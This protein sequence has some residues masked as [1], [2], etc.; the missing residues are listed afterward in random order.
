PEGGGGDGL[1]LVMELLRGETLE[2]HLKRR[3]P[4]PAREA[5][6]I[7]VLLLSALAHAHATGIVHRDVTPANVFLAIDP[8]GH[9]TP[10]LLDFGIAKVPAGDQQTLDGRALGTPRYMAPERIRDEGVLDG[11]SDLF[12]LGVVLYEM[13]TGVCPFAAASPAASLAAVLEA[14]VDPDPR[15]EPRVWLELRR[16]LAKRPYERPASAGAMAEGLLSAAGETENRLADALRNAPVSGE[17]SSAEVDPA[18]PTRTVGGHS[19]GARAIQTRRRA[20]GI[21]WATG[22]AIVATALGGWRAMAPRAAPPIDAR[23]VPATERATTASVPLPSAM[24]TSIA[25][26]A[27]TAPPA[28]SSSPGSPSPRPGRPRRARPIAT[29]PGF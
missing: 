2:R 16:A 11:R 18:G 9:V 4:L 22:I 20:R 13:L 21:A 25:P 24:A 6:A 19:Y 3:G 7:A 15:I 26:P 8:D 12:S 10:K 23:S 17:P 1:V 29:T 28:T 5:L 27:S 14:D